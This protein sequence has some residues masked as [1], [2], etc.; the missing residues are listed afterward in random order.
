MQCH[1]LLRKAISCSLYLRLVTYTHTLFIVSG[2]PKVCSV[3]RKVLIAYSPLIF[4]TESVY[5]KRFG[6][7]KLAVDRAV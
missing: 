7:Q 3:F 1:L 6:T 2:R 5:R 4:S